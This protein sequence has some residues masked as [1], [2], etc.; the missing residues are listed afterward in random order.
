VSPSIVPFRMATLRFNFVRFLTV[1]YAAAVSLVDIGSIENSSV[2]VVISR[3]PIQYL[4]VIKSTFEGKILR[5][6]V[7]RKMT[8][9][10]VEVISYN[11]NLEKIWKKGLIGARLR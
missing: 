10:K 1:L 3:V 2:S 11:L 9:T 7:K 8:A 4:Q 5:F 6:Q